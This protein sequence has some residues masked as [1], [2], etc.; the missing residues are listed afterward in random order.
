MSDLVA[1]KPMSIGHRPSFQ[2]FAEFHAA[3][4]VTEQPDAAACRRSARIA[5]VV[6]VCSVILAGAW[7]ELRVRM[8]WLNFPETN[9]TVVGQQRGSQPLSVVVTLR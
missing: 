3:S 5:R 4:E 6:R 2:R 9:S 8:P 1:T 7:V